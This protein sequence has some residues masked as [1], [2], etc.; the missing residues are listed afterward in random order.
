MNNE[1][2]KLNE[3]ELLNKIYK[4]NNPEMIKCLN[5]ATYR[6]MEKAQLRAVIYV[7]KKYGLLRSDMKESSVSD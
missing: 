5:E 7:A 4:L 2:V 3:E 6:E 1:N